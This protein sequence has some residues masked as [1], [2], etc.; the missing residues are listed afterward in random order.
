MQMSCCDLNL[1]FDNA[2]AI[3]TLKSCQDCILET[4]RCR[5]LKLGRGI[6]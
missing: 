5:K 4:A 6:G 2:V 1:T 3:L